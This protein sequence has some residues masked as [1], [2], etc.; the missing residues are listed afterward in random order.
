MADYVLVFRKPPTEGMMSAKPVTIDDPDNAEA[1]GFQQY[2]GEVDPQDQS[3]HPSPFCRK[4][5]A[6]G[7]N[8]WSIDIWRRYAEPVWW[9]IDVT[10]VL[11]CRTRR[12]R[13]N[14]EDQDRHICPLQ[15][16]VIRRSIQIWSEPG[17]VVLSP[18][19]GYGSEGVG[20]VEMRRRFVGIELNGKYFTEAT[21]QLAIAEAGLAQM[22][23]LNPIAL[24]MPEQTANP[25][26][27][28]DL[29]L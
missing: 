1:V 26:A 18:F 11:N 3:T 9:D 14:E 27:A 12:S 5:P 2:I 25:P 10:D 29:P 4:N 24:D 15:L 28:S 7:K 17:D 20:A 6:A 23:M 22:N 16:G 19:A 21:K 8:G 13:K